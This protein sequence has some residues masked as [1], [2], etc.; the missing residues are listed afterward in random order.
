MI[1]LTTE[2]KETTIDLCNQ[3]LVILNNRIDS[4]DEECNG[5]LNAVREYH[6]GV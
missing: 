5:Y 6:E 3:I 2:Q 4:L 1:E